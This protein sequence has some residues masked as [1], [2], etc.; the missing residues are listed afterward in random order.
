MRRS[1]KVLFIA[2][3]V[4]AVMGAGYVVRHPF[5]RKTVLSALFGVNY[6]APL[7]FTAEEARDTE[8]ELTDNPD[9]VAARTALIQYYQ[10]HALLLGPA[11][12]EGEAL[13]EKREQHVLWLVRHHPDFGGVDPVS[14]QIDAEESHSSEARALWLQQVASHADDIAVLSNAAAA[15]SFEPEISRE[16]ASRG[17]VIRPNDPALLRLVAESF[18]RE[19]RHEGPGPERQS[20]ARRALESW[21]K[22][23][24]VE[25]SEKEQCR[26]YVDLAIVAYEAGNLPKAKRYA[27]DLLLHEQPPTGYETNIANTVLGRV[28]LR[29]GDVEEAKRRLK[30]SALVDTYP[31]LASFGP[32]MSLAS[33]LLDRNEKGAVI[34]Y[35]HQCS[36]FWELGAERLK[37]WESDIQSGK[38]PDFGDN[39]QP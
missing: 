18:T 8:A 2:S 10:Y 3:V 28:A 35:L 29:R 33:E 17:L 37:I 7:E 6:H 4:L 27:N 1:A 20:T 26:H 34:D 21:E 39:L 23:E 13:E 19:V 11:T 16:I 38:R 15:L 31:V 24:G 25:P 22:Y 12:S 32:R 14:F 5:K 36:R 30:A 9:N